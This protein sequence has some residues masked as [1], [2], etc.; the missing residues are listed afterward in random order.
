SEE[1][2]PR[3]DAAREGGAPQRAQNA[4]LP[5]TE[6]GAGEPRDG[7][8]GV[9]ILALDALRARVAA[10][11]PVERRVSSPAIRHLGRAL[12]DDRAAG[13][14]VLVRNASAQPAH[15]ELRLPR[16]R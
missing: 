12:G 7:A 16:T 3:E 14:V 10:T 9:L 13:A 2:A 8:T 5:G 15:T 6:R 4:A 1:Q 11:T